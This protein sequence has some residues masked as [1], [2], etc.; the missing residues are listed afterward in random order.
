MQEGPELDNVLQFPTQRFWCSAEGRHR[1]FPATCAGAPLGGGFNAPL[2]E[3]ISGTTT[4]GCRWARCEVCKGLG[5]RSYAPDAVKAG[6]WRLWEGA[7]WRMFALADGRAEL[8]IAGQ[9]LVLDR[10]QQR[11]LGRACGLAHSAGIAAGV[12]AAGQHLWR[13]ESVGER[14]LVWRV[15]DTGRREGFVVE[16]R[17]ARA[18]RPC[19]RCHRTFREPE[20]WQ[21]TNER[22]TAM[23][24]QPGCK[25]DAAKM[26]VC[27]GC[28]RIMLAADAPTATVAR[29][30]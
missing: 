17:K 30:P 10:Q 15:G 21:V 7:A 3:T 23:D 22:P 14:L 27:W 5:M 9:V 19:V 11:E 24:W 18:A 16:R 13:A 29:T 8:V 20:V 26:R 12:V 25:T 6:F 4:H 28:V 1:W 2:S